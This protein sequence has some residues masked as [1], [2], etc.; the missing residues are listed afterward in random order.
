MI[1]KLRP[2]SKPTVPRMGKGQTAI[3][4]LMT[5]GWAILAVVI[6]VAVLFY[7]G[8][9]SPRN[10]APNSCQLPAGFSCYS[11][12]ISGNA[13]LYLDLGQSTGKKVRITGIAC[14]KADSPSLASA[15]ITIDSGSHAV[16]ANSNVTCKE[17]NDSS[18]GNSSSYY[19]GKIVI[20][21]T[22]IETGLPHQIKGE[23]AGR[24]EG[25]AGG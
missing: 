25:Y 10:V 21:Y 14:S 23:I 16:V 2:P 17:P 7:L 13:S 24:L 20:S 1:Y 6:V 11:F 5:Y 3:E 4:F 15:N 22:E 18:P 9:F 19:R 8:V 12:K